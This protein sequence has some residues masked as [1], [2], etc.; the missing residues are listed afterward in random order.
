MIGLKRA[1]EL[2]CSATQRKEQM[3]YRPSKGSM[4]DPSVIWHGARYCAFM[5]YNQDGPN[6]LDAQHCLRAVSDDGVHWKDD[7]V[8]IEERERGN[9]C[10]LSRCAERFILG[11]GVARD[12]GQDT[13]RFYESSDLESW[14]YLHSSNPDPRWYVSTGRWCRCPRF[15]LRK[16]RILPI[17][18]I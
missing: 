14:H 17:Y 7:G 3:I 1:S 13:F 18:C 15:R 12:E 8:V 2:N 16:E 5:M 9:K 6:G 10:F 11:H 4:W